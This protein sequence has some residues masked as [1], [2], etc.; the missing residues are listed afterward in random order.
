LFKK[1]EER[2]WFS[3]QICP[4]RV[5]GVKMTLSLSLSQLK[6]CKVRV[7]TLKD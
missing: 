3:K 5:E 4:Y 6:D 2:G 1:I 7:V